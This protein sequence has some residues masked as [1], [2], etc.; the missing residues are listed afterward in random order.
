M[1]REARRGI[2]DFESSE[3]AFRAFFGLVGRDV[4]I[5]FLLGDDFLLDEETI[6]TDARRAIDQFLVLFG[7]GKDGKKNAGGTGDA[8]AAGEAKI[9]II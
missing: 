5:R 3:E 4:Q 6:A 2:L 9:S 1:R 7:T 8:P